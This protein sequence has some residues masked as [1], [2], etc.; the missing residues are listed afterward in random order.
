MRDLLLHHRRHVIGR[1]P[2][3]LADLAMSRQTGFE[4]DIDVP[5]LVGEQPARRLDFVLRD[6]GVGLHAGM[7]FIAGAI[8]EAGIDEHHAIA[9]GANA[10][11]QVHRGA[12]LFVHDA[13][14]ERAWLDCQRLFDAAEK[15][16]RGRDLFRPVHL[17]FDDVYAAATAVAELAVAEQIVLGG[18]TGHHRIEKCL[19]DFFAIAG[20]R[21]GIHMGADITHEHHAAARQAKTLALWRNVLRIGIEAA[22]ERLVSAHDRGLEIALH[23]AQ[24]VTVDPHLV[25]GIDRGHRILAIHDGSD[26]G[27]DVDVVDI[28]QIALA[29]VITFADQQFDMQIIVAE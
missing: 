23:Q 7:D 19:G 16:H 20:N 3:A 24:P 17:R 13:N 21:V 15:L 9:S 6:H 14:L 26:R 18:E 29:D 11:L 12:A 28:G 5:V 1:G 22:L 2:H 10:L 25:L 27:F 4:P 8:E